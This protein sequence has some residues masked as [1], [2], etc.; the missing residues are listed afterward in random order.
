MKKAFVRIQ[1][2]LPTIQTFLWSMLSGVIGTLILAGFFSSIMS[3]EFLS[4]LL[5]LIAGFNAAISGFMLIERT[6]GQIKKEK[7]AASA[8][9]ALAAIVSCLSINALCIHLNVLFLIY[10]GLGMTVTITGAIAA[11]FGG[12]LAV[13]HRELKEKTVVP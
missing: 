11:W 5:P 3:L 1:C 12:L 8:V 4:A 7:T 6:A 9:G 13:K 10:G 2:E